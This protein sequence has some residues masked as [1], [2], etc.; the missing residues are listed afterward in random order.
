MKVGY[1]C[2]YG[3][4]NAGKSTLLNAILGLKI[5]AVSPKPQT[6]RY[7]VQ[8]IYTDSD[9]QII[10][11]DTPGLHRPHG[12]LGS[13][14]LQEAEDARSNVD[15]L[16][17]VVD[18]S[19]RRID[20]ETASKISKMNIPVIVVFNK[21]DKISLEEG[22]ERLSEYSKILP[23]A[24]FIQMSALKKFGVDEL[25]NAIKK[26][27]EEGDLLYPED[28]LIDRPTRFVWAEMIREKC[29]IN[30][31]KEIPHAVHVEITHVEDNP[32]LGK[33]VI[34]ADIIVEKS[35]EKAIIIGRNGQKLS[36]IRKHAE[37]S[38]S[39]F[40]QEKVALEL[41]VKVVPDWRNNPAKLQEYGYKD[42]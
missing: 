29:M 40:M 1:A 2:L 14:L 41:Y 4:A 17:Y 9:S 31:E 8:G 5:E 39:N 34:F 22:M 6:T 24:E 30:T 28:Q 15:V 21:I 12:R 19:Y 3:L 26:H 25:L 36:L 11:I 37:H 18:G 27:L 42:R 13:I 7:N 16:V 33:K 38:I 35:S 10:F 20:T 23:N 32:D